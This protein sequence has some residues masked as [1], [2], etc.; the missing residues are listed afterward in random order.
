M[1]PSGWIGWFVLITRPVSMWTG[2]LSALLSLLRCFKRHS[3]RRSFDVWW[4]FH[5]SWW[6]SQTKWPPGVY[7]RGGWK[8]KHLYKWSQW[9][10]KV[11]LE[12]F[13][14]SVC[15]KPGLKVWQAKWISEWGWD[16]FSL[17]STWSPSGGGG[18]HH[19]SLWG[20]SPSILMHQPFISLFIMLNRII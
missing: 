19:C 20:P 18:S 6:W 3:C 2:P 7:T 4:H 1:E 17:C 8:G 11:C 5:W 14:Q 15:P 10:G 9:I 12:H 16:P 13:Q